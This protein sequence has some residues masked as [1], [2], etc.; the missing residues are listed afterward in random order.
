MK[1]G[2]NT[3]GLAFHRWDDAIRLIAETGYTSVAITVDHYCLNPYAPDLPQQIVAMQELLTEFQLSSVIETGARFLLDPRVKHEPTLVSPSK[4]ERSRRIDFL[5]HCVDLAAA[6]DSDAVSFWAGQLK[7][8]LPR[9]EALQRLAAGCREVIDYAAAQ[10]VKLAFEPEPGM[11]IE[12]LSDFRE[13]LTLVDHPCFGL[14]VDIGHLQCMGELPISQH[15]LPWRERIFNIHIED[16]LKGV[17]DHL[18]FGEGEIDFTD[19][20]AG[21]RQIDYQ[22]G[23][24]VELSRHSHMAPE[25]LRESWSFLESCLKSA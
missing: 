15:L 20:F 24:H 13:L 2:Y 5:K 3:N 25:V 11:V 1:P 17:H 12:T 19:V 4:E 7:Q 16:M 21:L 6:L 8:D 9:E 23:L 14:T 18:R 10:N 22:G